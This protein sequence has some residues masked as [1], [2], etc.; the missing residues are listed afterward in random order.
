MPTKYELQAELRSLSKGIINM[1][2]TSLKKNDL[3]QRIALFKGF[4]GEAE[5]LPPVENAKGGP[6]GP[7]KVPVAETAITAAGGAG[8]GAEIGIRVPGAPAERPTNKRPAGRP[9]VSK[10]RISVRHIEEGELTAD[11][12]PLFPGV[13]KAAARREVPAAPASG[14]DDEL[15]LK[16]MRMLRA[17]RE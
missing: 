16:V 6:L 14:S 13:T 2:I 7:R 10:P 9:K 3:E 4:K 17:M 15:A 12:A 1:P 8:A 11:T 5:K